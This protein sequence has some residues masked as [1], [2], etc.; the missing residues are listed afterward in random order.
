MSLLVVVP[1]IQTV[2]KSQQI[3]RRIRRI[4]L[5]LSFSFFFTFFLFCL[6][7]LGLGFFF[8]PRRNG[9]GSL[10]YDDDGILYSFDTTILREGAGSNRKKNTHTCTAHRLSR[11]ASGWVHLHTR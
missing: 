5:F 3:Q 4:C 6:L 9:S 7:F 1:C 2:N 11:I 10:E 8:Y